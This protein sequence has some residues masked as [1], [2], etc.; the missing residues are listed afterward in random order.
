MKN[1]RGKLQQNFAAA[2]LSVRI[3]ASIFKLRNK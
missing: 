3:A 1:F 2:H